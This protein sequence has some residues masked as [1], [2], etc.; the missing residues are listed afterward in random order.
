MKTLILDYEKWRCGSDGRNK[1]GKGFTSLENTFG[2]QC[3]LGQFSYQ[4]NKKIK[5]EDLI[6]KGEPEN[7]KK[8]IKGLSYYPNNGYKT[9][10]VLATEAVI[11]NDDNMTTPEEK[12]VL[13][14]KLFKTKGFTIKVINKPK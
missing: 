10:T 5:K 8:I 2:F 3:C 13:L 1:L 4:L 14:R 9:N 11:I 12:I 7:V 6:N